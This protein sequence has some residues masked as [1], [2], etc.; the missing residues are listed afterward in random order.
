MQAN[1]M[2]HTLSAQP[3]ALASPS[4]RHRP[5]ADD[6]PILLEQG[7]NLPQETRSLQN[8]CDYPTAVILGDLCAVIALAFLEPLALVCFFQLIGA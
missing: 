2:P 8:S 3:P 7:I 4:L 6:M 5:M 1:T